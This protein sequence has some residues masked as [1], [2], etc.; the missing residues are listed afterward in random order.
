LTPS[1]QCNLVYK[2][3]KENL[4]SPPC[5]NR[6]RKSVRKIITI[7]NGSSIQTPQKRRRYTIITPPLRPFPPNL[8]PPHQVTKQSNMRDEVDRERS[9][10]LLFTSK[11]ISLFALHDPNKNSCT[12]LHGK[13]I[14]NI[15]QAFISKKLRP[16]RLTQQRNKH[17]HTYRAKKY[18]PA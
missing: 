17:K 16:S 1:K 5:V 2:K 3:K 9:L 8:P 4:R 7:E 14:D 15:R 11:N 18:L 13:R 12:A 6:D 10:F